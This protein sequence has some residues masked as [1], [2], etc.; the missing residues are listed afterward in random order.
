MSA[1]MQALHDEHKELFP[2]VDELRSSAAGITSN[3]SRLLRER[4]APNVE[5][6]A[7]HLLIHAMAEDEV[8][9][10]AVERAMNAPGAT[11]TMAFEHTVVKDLTEELAALMAAIPASGPSSAQITDAQRLLYSLHAVV[12]SHFA[13]EEAIFVPALE[14]ALSQPEADKLYAEMEAAAGRIR[15]ALEPAT[16]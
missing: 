12:G 16:A 5:F 13:K 11:A 8:L 9:Y 3:N 15:Q 10:P 1:T 7:D 2:H 6:L 14:A 4:I